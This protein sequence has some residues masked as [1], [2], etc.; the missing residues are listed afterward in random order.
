MDKRLIA[1]YQGEEEAV[2]RETM[3][4]HVRRI[5]S[6]V[7]HPDAYD[8]MIICYYESPDT[9]RGMRQGLRSLATAILAL[10]QGN[11]A[12]GRRYRRMGVIVVLDDGDAE[13][14]EVRELDFHA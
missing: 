13:P 6:Q 12:Q 4:A 2:D 7:E 9:S 10:I 5:A 1:D 8:R 3:R 11:L 14:R